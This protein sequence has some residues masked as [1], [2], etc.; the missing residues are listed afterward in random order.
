MDPQTNSAPASGAIA[1]DAV[2]GADRLP[3]V[4]TVGFSG[5]RLI[6]DAAEAGRL[7]AEALAAIGAAFEAL[8]GSHADAFEG[9]P[10]L[11]LLIGAAPG[12][13]R[14][15]AAAWRAARLGEVHLI[16]PFREP[17]GPGAYT[18][19]PA[20]VDSETR[21]ETPP[22]GEPWTGIDSASLG[23]DHELAHAE[24]G[25]WIVRHADLLVGWWNGAPPGGPGGAGDTVRRALE[26]GLP[27]IWLQPG[28][29]HPR[30]VDPTHLNQHAEAAETMARLADIA[31]PLDA[32]R[33]ASVL[34]PALSPP[35]DGAGDAET[36]A[37]RDYA[38]VDPMQ[39]RTGPIGVAQ[40]LLDQTLWRA[41]PLF[42]SLAGGVRAPSDELG[43]APP[44]LA[45]QPGF[46]R[47]RRAS[48]D[49]AARS[50]H[51]SS[52]HRSEQ[53][54]LIMI[55][56]AAVFTG[57]LP[58]LVASGETLARTHAVAA[59]TEFALGAAAFFLAAAARRAHR[60]RR[61]SDARRLA[62]RLRAARA[63]WP[64][65]F[66]IADASAQPSATWTEWRARAVLR[67]AGPPR[68][69]IDRPRF[70]A[71]AAWVAGQLIGGQIDYHAR[72]H[73][74]AEH[75][76]RFVRRI[77]GAAF[78]V[79]MLTL[80]SYLTLTWTAP[81][82]GWTPPHWV[83]GLVTLVSAVA[84]AVGAGCL[85]LEATN[86]FGELARHSEHL[87]GEFEQ[88]RERLG[89]IERQTYHQVQAIIRRAA[90][91]VVE[92]ADAWRDRALRR[93]IVRGG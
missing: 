42:E 60:H 86:G 64:L 81:F 14:L 54:L 83:G 65:G 40:A 10:R 91:L 75:I 92:D 22:A 38:A 48:R 93:R 9:A 26:R 37:R 34:A 53:L 27:V 63:T 29:P 1:G 78:A 73:Q 45:A 71:E 19:D 13:D 28:E 49:A 76:E 67:A 41:F 72:Q 8:K 79:L 57:A 17:A 18:D 20:K 68:G 36:N 11:R 5:H 25:R 89:D 66:D 69:W 33:L 85:A 12:T 31:E 59:E 47:L 24:V 15:A 6:E 39:R 70:D 32:S 61:W 87:E 50:I 84:P 7:I 21:V 43:V 2:A 3:L 58:A 56:I 80:L 30:L 90:Q 51:L 23:L 4:L 77:E 74:I 55:A 46:Q 88:L 62:E 16:Y 82:T 35:G 44:T 52:I